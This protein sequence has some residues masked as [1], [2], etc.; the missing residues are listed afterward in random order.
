MARWAPL[1]EGETCLAAARGQHLEVDRYPD[2][3]HDC[4]DAAYAMSELYE[5]LLECRRP[6]PGAGPQ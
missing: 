5:W 6:G 3:D 2:L 1:D 4:W